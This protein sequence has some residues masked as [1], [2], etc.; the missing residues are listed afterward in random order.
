MESTLGS[1]WY[2]FTLLRYAVFAAGALVAVAAVLSWAV[3]T[4][5]ISPFSPV[6]RFIRRFDGPLFASMERRVVRAGGLP[7][8]APWWTLAAVVIGGLILLSVIQF[9]LEQVTLVTFSI[10]GQ[11]MPIAAVLVSWTVGFLR[12]AIMARVISSWVGGGPYSKWWRWSYVTTDWFLEPLRR[13]IPTIGPI[14]ISP[15]VAYFA[16]GLLQN[17]IIGAIT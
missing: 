14:D 4:R 9:I 17:V 3:R 7:S 15:L 6:A 8:S 13:V 11:G 2:F 12:I 1:L 16:L 10:R 5:K